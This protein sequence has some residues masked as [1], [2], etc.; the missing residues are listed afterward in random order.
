[1]EMRGV[2]PS[3]YVAF[4]AVVF[5]AQL[6]GMHEWEPRRSCRSRS[7]PRS[8]RSS[9]RGACACR[10]GRRRTR[11]PAPALAAVATGD[12]SAAATTEF[13]SVPEPAATQ[14]PEQQDAESGTRAEPES[15]P[16]PG[17]RSPNR[18]VRQ[19]NRR[20]APSDG[21]RRSRQLCRRPSSTTPDVSLAVRG[22]GGGRDP[23]RTDGSSD[24]AT[25]GS[26]NDR[27]RPRARPGTARSR[28]PR[29]RP[30]GGRR[31]RPPG[32]KSSSGR[33]R[34][35]RTSSALPNAE[36]GRAPTRVR[37]LDLIAATARRARRPG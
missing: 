21:L 11:P 16:E 22:V 15:E 27:A 36:A 32:R 34:G 25:V 3:A 7:S 30:A 1:M 9:G 2:G 23:P 8:C 6:V 20:R 4:A 14:S 5:A 12:A 17:A 28:R 29:G 13:E 26:R 37:P 33:S 31:D 18:P 24:P 35:S 19:R 10:S